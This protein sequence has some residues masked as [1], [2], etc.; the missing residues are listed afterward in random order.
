MIDA[1]FRILLAIYAEGSW[2]VLGF[3]VLV[4]LLGAGGGLAALVAVGVV[5]SFG[6]LVASTS[7]SI[8]GLASNSV[9]SREFADF[10]NRLPRTYC[11]PC[12]SMT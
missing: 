9:V 3:L 2:I 11:F 12:I 10:S 4:L 5:E 6:V 1:H 8:S 7:V